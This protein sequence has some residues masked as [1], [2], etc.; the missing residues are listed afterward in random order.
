MGPSLPVL[1]NFFSSEN[2]TLR[3][4]SSDQL[5]CALANDN[6]RSRFLS[7][8]NGLRRAT[9]PRSLLR[10]R[11]RRTVDACTNNWWYWAI[12]AHSSREERRRFRNDKILSLRRSAGLNFEGLPGRFLVC[13]DPV[14]ACRRM[15]SITV[16]LGTC[17]VRL[18]N[19]L[20]WPVSVMV[21]DL[22]PH[23]LRQLFS[24]THFSAVSSTTLHA[25]SR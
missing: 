20:D 9:H 14:S 15:V 17:K 25:L 22:W 6:L 5:R 11:W 16:V 10:K 23:S 19:E 4:C 3:H 18:M 2:S 12:S 21:N 7:E 8:M 24:A 1:L 13:T